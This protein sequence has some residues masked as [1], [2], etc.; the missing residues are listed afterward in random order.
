[1]PPALAENMAQYYAFH[2]TADLDAYVACAQEAKDAGVYTYSGGLDETVAPVRV[3][4][5]GTVTEDTYPQTK[6]LDGGFAEARL[7]L[8]AAFWRPSAI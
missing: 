6:E 7:N 5:D 8:A 3:S 2:A 1:M 4:G